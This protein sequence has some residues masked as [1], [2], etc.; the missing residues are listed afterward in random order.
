V[1]SKGRTMKVSMVELVLVAVT[2]DP[3]ME[4]A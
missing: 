3:E 1:S 2:Q 4:D